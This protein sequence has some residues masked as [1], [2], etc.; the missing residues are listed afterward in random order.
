MSLSFCV[1]ASG[2]SGNCTV[3]ICEGNGQRTC[4][5]IDAGLS[6]RATARRLKPLG[7][8]L[9]DLSLALLTHLDKDHLHP[10]WRKAIKRFNLNLRLHIHERHRR[11]A[12]QA[13]WSARCVDLFNG[14]IDLN[15]CARVKSLMLAHDDLGSVGFVIEHACMRLGYATDL[16]RVPPSMLRHFVDLDALAIESNY[17]RGMQLASAR[18]A[19]LKRRIM[20]GMG[21]LSNEQALEAV[22]QI[23]G[24]SRLSH[25][26]LLHLSRHCNDPALV[27]QLY[28][29]R[30]PYLVD[31][32]TITNQYRPSPLLRIDPARAAAYHNRVGRAEQMSLFDLIKGGVGAES[33]AASGAAA[34]A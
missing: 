27:Q 17:D 14:S 15:G 23:D 11:A 16:G 18:P 32:L 24:C 19:F 7:L 4:V 13:G 25:I 2:S 3:L 8:G 6:P 33:A 22:R 26:V 20:G 30:A 31:R 10:G 34:V 5:M 9:S 1:L 21:H 12:W 28:S 29:T